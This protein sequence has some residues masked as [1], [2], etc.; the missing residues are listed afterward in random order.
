LALSSQKPFGVNFAWDPVKR[1]NTLNE[2]GLDFA[3]AHQAFD[4]FRLNQVDDRFDYGE[5]RQ[6]LTGTV[7]G[8]VVIIVW[9]QRT[10]TRRIISMRKANAKEIARYQAALDRSR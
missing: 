5:I 10:S 7:N 2:R 4:N 9:T 6:V 8:D 3:D 1:A